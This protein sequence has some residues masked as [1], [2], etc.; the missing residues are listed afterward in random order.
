MVVASFDDGHKIREPEVCLKWSISEPE[1]VITEPK[2]VVASFDPKRS[3]H[4]LQAD[5][6]RARE[7]AGRGTFTWKMALTAKCGRGIF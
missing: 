3:W 4:L 1:V 2:V 6:S 5:I 7:S